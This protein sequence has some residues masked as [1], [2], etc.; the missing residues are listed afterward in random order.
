MTDPAAPSTAPESLGYQLRPPPGVEIRYP[1]SLTLGGIPC[2][3]EGTA[4][5][6]RPP[7]GMDQPTARRH[8][9]ATLHDWLFELDVDRGWQ[10]EVSFTGSVWEEPAS[11][12]GER[13]WRR[14]LELGHGAAASNLGVL[15]QER[16]DL[17]GAEDAWRRG[18]ELG[19]GAAAHNLGV[20]LQERGD[21][22]AAVAALK[23]AAAS[24][25]AGAAQR[26][27]RLLNSC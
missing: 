5:T 16:G 23:H 9:E 22:K 18:L 10:V 17:D 19:H 15:L 12:T 7:A 14:G 24:E 27:R 1:P 2:T 4:L 6:G 13:T 8:V 25:D 26:A 3:V 21:L 11:A 20:L